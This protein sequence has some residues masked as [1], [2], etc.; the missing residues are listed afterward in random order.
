MEQPLTRLLVTADDVGLHR[1]ITLGALEAASR[2][3]VCSL[4]VLT[5]RDDWDA[6]RSALLGHP[7]LDLGVHLTLC[8]GRPVSSPDEVRSLVGSDGRFPLRGRT[9]VQAV[10]RGSVD[11]DE[12]RTEWLAQVRRVQ[13]AGLR[14]THLDGH[15]HLHLLPGLSTVF[16]EV[17]RSCEIPGARLVR[18]AGRGP[19]TGVRAL[20][21][22][23]SWRMASRLR[24]GGSRVVD[25][26]VGVGVSG[27]L[28]EEALLSII[29]R[30]EPGTT[31]LICH[32]A[33]RVD[34]FPADL[35]SEGLDWAADYRFSDELAA[36]CSPAVAARIEERGIVLVGYGGL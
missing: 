31:E 4:S 34:G 3:I 6:T 14:V 35:V 17:R 36:L 18:E 15:K 30:L 32:P 10:L 9:V 23:L 29:E 28:T 24:D 21:S 33:K 19:R 25:R 8:E 13:D 22:A 26:T 12:V 20:L 7:D 5:A 1:G 2:G 27:A 11:K 16:E